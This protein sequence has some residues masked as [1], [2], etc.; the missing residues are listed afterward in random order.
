MKI[1][2]DHLA[3]GAYIYIRQSTVDQLANNHESR[4]RQYGLA[5]RARALGWTDVTVIDDDLGR[6]GSGVSRPG[7]EKLLAAIC[8]GRVGAVFAIEVSRL[9]RNGRDWHTLIEFCGLVGTVIVDEDGTYEPRHPN[10]R[11]LLGMKGTMSELELSLLRARSMEALKQKARRGELFFTVAVGYVKVGRDK[12]EMD[13]DLRVR[14]AIGLVFTRFAEMQSIRQVFLSLRSDQIALPYINPRISGQQH[15]LWKPPVYT[16]VSNLLTNPVYAGAYA[17]GRTGSRTIIENGR[18]RI[19]R[20]RRKTRSDWAVLLVD[21]HEGY[22]SWADFERNQRL[23]ADNANGKG[24]M[25]R[26]PVRKGEALLAGLLRCGH[27]GRRLLVGY[28]GAKGD[29]GRYKCDA[30]RSN[31]D[32]DPY[33]SFGA[34]RVDEA[35]GA[36]IVRLLQPLGVEAAIQ[37]IAQREHQSGEKQRQ[38]ELALEQARYEAIRARRQYDMVDPENRLVAHELERR[39]NGALAAVRALEEELEA[40]VR[41]RPAA[42][43]A[44]ECQRLLQMGAD[45]EAAWHHPAATAVTRKR[46]IRVVLREVVAHVEGDQIHL[47]LHWQG[48]DHTR[49]TVRKN[50]RGQTRWSVEPETVELIRACARLMPDKAIAGLL[51]RA[52]KRTGRSN[53]WSQSRVRGFRNTHGIAVYRDGEWAERGEVTLTEAA[54]MLNLSS[55]TVLRQIRAGIIPAQQYCKG[56]P[57]V[58][59]RRNIED[60]HLIEHAGPCLN[61]P[62]SSNPEQKTFVFQ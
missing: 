3:R 45:L 27:C 2:S 21:H 25:V 20:G 44:E 60:S 30:T 36:E 57:W 26:G 37:A 61:G 62:S 23:I 17:F 8:E 28:N 5:D 32:G 18:K 15:V 12:I 59:K 38:I 34:L 13:P 42:L 22:L 7:F 29:V 4:R 52:G 24:M 55:A 50:R 51:N 6:S 47:L 19:V 46:I 11:L 58:I 16:T 56:A 9:A 48:G 54:R 40:L 49:L 33:I 35:V 43:S 39:W 53:G 10:D 41:Q 31:P 14:E 1:T